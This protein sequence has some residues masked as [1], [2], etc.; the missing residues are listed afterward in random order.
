M[1]NSRV[2]GK[3]ATIMVE[4]EQ[5]VTYALPMLHNES[6]KYMRTNTC[7][8]TP[9]GTE[10]SVVGIV[11]E[12][13]VG[14]GVRML[15]LDPKEAKAFIEGTVTIFDGV[16]RHPGGY[17]PPGRK[18]RE[19]PLRSTPTG[20][21]RPPNALRWTRIRCNGRLTSPWSS[22]AAPGSR[23]NSPRLWISPGTST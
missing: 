3:H 8:F 13:P 19:S 4:T 11:G 17:N 16:Q 6:K 23:S 2:V 1:I 5:G 7:A 10:A 15:Q 20:T 18:K 14:K 9:T 22:R 12:L 21:R